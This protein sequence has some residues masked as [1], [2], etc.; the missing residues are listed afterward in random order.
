MR[1]PQVADEKTLWSLKAV[2]LAREA[3]H[4]QSISCGER[5]KLVPLIL[6]LFPPFKTPPTR[7]CSSAPPSAPPHGTRHRLAARLPP[8]R[9]RFCVFIPPARCG[10]VRT[11]GAAGLEQLFSSSPATRTSS[12][13]NERKRSSEPHVGMNKREESEAA[14]GDMEGPA[15]PGATSPYSNLDTNPTRPDPEGESSPPTS[16]NPRG[17]SLQLRRM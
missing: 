2:T 16:D 5:W 17:W 10:A 12:P 3:P 6:D 14:A 8:R 7:P 15:L 9:T 13:G 1:D 4:A 11:S